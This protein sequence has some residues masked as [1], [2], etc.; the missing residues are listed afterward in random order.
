VEAKVMGT[1]RK[2]HAITLSIKAKDAKAAPA[3]KAS[4]KSAKAAAGGAAAGTSSGKKK[5]S[6]ESGLKTTLGDLF[7]DHINN[8]EE[9]E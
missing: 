3:K 7:K 4:A 8:N 1:D 6:A 5:K 9:K 2:V